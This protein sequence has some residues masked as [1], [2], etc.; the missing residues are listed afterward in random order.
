MFSGTWFHSRIVTVRQHR[1]ERSVGVV[2]VRDSLQTYVGEWQKLQ[3]LDERDAP[4]VLV[5]AHNATVQCNW[6]KLSAWEQRHL[7]RETSDSATV[8]VA[9][10]GRFI[11][12]GLVYI[13]PVT[14]TA[15]GIAIDPRTT[16]ALIEGNAA[17]FLTRHPPVL[18]HLLAAPCAI[19]EC[20]AYQTTINVY[21]DG[22]CFREVSAASI[23]T[24]TKSAVL[25][26]CNRYVVQF[27][28]LFA[29]SLGN[30]DA[31]IVSLAA[32]TSERHVRCTSIQLINA[33]RVDGAARLSAATTAALCAA[34]RIPGLTLVTHCCVG[35][36]YEWLKLD[37]AVG[38]PAEECV[39]SDGNVNETVTGAT[40]PPY[41]NEDNEKLAKTLADANRQPGATIFSD[42]QALQAMKVLQTYCDSYCKDTASAHCNGLLVQFDQMPSRLFYVPSLFSLLN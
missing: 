37:T 29:Q 27:Q 15:S 34:H 9:K 1:T 36:L 17:L 23:T 2:R 30:V 33:E 11:S 32:A 7:R 4:L 5:L 31:I 8:V 21:F 12:F 42:A 38:E 25:A 3:A 6:E 13:M 20:H 28:Q 26:F 35:G 22:Q 24:A 19:I 14:P 10:I 41:Y 40:T 39:G 18:R 16:A